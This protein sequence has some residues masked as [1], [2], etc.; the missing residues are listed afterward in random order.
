MIACKARSVSVRGMP[1]RSRLRDRMVAGSLVS[2][3]AGRVTPDMYGVTAA[4]TLRRKYTFASRQVGEVVGRQFAVTPSKDA[5]VVGGR[6]EDDSGARVCQDAGPE[7]R[8]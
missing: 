8:G 4:P 1:Y 3:G 5:G 6:L 2:G 7:R